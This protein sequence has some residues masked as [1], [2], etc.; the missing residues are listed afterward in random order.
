MPI[1]VAPDSLASCAAMMP[2]RPSP[3]TTT[4][5][6][7]WMSETRI[8]VKAI[9]AMRTMGI[10]RRSTPSGTLAIRFHGFGLVS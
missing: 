10:S 2:T 3:D 1:T 5:S 9:V 8:D 6:P 4:K 7:S